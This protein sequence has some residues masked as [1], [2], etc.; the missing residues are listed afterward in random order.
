VQALAALLDIARNQEGK[1]AQIDEVI[2][3]CAR[4]CVGIMPREYHSFIVF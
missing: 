2:Y 3:L 4:E 1:I